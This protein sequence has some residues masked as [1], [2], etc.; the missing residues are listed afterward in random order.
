MLYRLPDGN[1]T[2]DISIENPAAKE[3]G[4]SKAILDDLPAE[5]ANGIAR[6]P[7]VSDGALHRIVIEL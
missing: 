2:Y 6:L 3:H 4:V 7:L 1:T 5:V